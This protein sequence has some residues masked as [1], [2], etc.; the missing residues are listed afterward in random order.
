MRRLFEHLGYRV[1]VATGAEEAMAAIADPLIDV[2]VTD[3]GLPGGRS[4][5]DLVADAVERRPDLGLVLLTADA[6][7]IQRS[8]LP[9]VAFLVKPVDF[10]TL[11]RAVR[12]ALQSRAPGGGAKT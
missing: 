11:A 12:A 8:P 6:A 4:G 9:G 5:F 1:S 7:R 2:L 10:G 3:V